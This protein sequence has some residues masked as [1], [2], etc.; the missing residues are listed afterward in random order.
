MAVCAASQKR[1]S[2]ML[3]IQSSES[4][5]EARLSPSQ[6]MMLIDLEGIAM[7]WRRDMT[8]LWHQR[9]RLLG[10]VARAVVWL[11]ALGFGLRRSFVPV[12]GLTYEQFVFPGIIAMTI[13]FSGLQS[14]ISIVYDREFGFLK[15]VLVAPTP[16]STLVIGKCLGGASSATIQAAIVF[17]F[18][19]FAAVHLTL[20]N[21][22]LTLITMFITAL[23]VSAL[24]VIIAISISDFENFGT[25][26]NFITLPLYM[27]S[28]AIFPTNGVPAWLHVILLINPLTYGVDAIRG[29]LLGYNLG[30]VPFDCVMLL[31]FTIVLVAIAIALAGREM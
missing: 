14:A 26:Q 12:S 24:G 13:I 22:S 23:A 2:I 20:V 5:Q 19:P 6:G 28:G 4:S 10:A 9:S 16:R 25:F 17:L 31:T 3:K 7:I 30:N 1:D 15:E 27:F 8:R 21:V 18:A 29:T 11:F